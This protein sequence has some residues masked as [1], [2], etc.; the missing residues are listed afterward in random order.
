M[1]TTRKPWTDDENRALVALYFE[2]LDCATAGRPYNKA[3]LIRI[4]QNAS[5]HAAK[6]FD[7]PFTGRLKDRSRGSIEAK[8]MNATAAHR[9]LCS[10]DETMDSHGY[11]ALPNYQA[12]LKSAVLREVERRTYAAN[13]SASA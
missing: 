13:T 12:S 11:R 9:D 3:A 1:T 4:A 7:Y 5:N 6:T 10:N 8:L 2:M